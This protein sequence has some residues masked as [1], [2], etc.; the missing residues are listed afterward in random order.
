MIA[1]VR[2]LLAYRELLLVWT[3]REIKVRYK[4]SLLGV[5]WAV[6]Q[7]AALTVMFSLV[8]SVL[9]R[10]PTGDAPYPIFAYAGLVPWTFFST[11]ISFGVSSLVNNMNL[12]TKIYFPREILPLSTILAAGVDFLIAGA[13][14]AL[15]MVWYR[16]PVHPSFIL[17]PVLVM[18]QIVLM[19][20]VVLL[21]SAALVFYRDVRFAVPLILQ[22]WLYASPVIYP[23]S[24]VPP[25]WQA[26]YRINPMVGLIEAYRDILVY[27]QWPQP[28]PLIVSA[29]VAFSLCLGAYAWFQRK[30]SS[31]ADLI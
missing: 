2:Q 1:S 13:L 25:E 19:L 14:Y 31:F 5:L 22:V 17:I 11:A 16:I 9:V 18:I 4:Q 15:L 10:V 12:V 21:G 6:L 7:P 30:E 23:S 28:E 8:F 20:G 27:G 29:V 3:S 24:L 26:L